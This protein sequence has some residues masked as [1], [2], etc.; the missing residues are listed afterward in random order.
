VATLVEALSGRKTRFIQISAAG[1]CETA[2]TEF[3]RS[4]MRGDRVLMDSALDWIILRPTLVL[5]PHAYG[6]TALLR[7]SA[8]FPVVGL[9]MLPDTVVQTVYVEDLVQAVVQ[10]A[11]GGIASGTIADVS[12]PQAHGFQDLVERVRRWQGFPAWNRF[13]RV[14]RPLMLLIARLADGL[15]WL[16][17]RS[18]LRTTAIL[19]LESGVTGNPDDGA[20]ANRVPCRSLDDTLTALPATVQERC[21]ARM[22]L[23]LPLAVAVLSLFWIVSGLIGFANQETAQ[24]V[25]TSRGFSPETAMSAVILGSVVDIVL[26]GGILVRGWARGAALGMIAVSFGYLAAAVIWTPDLWAHPLGPTVKVIPGMAL[27][28]VVAAILEPR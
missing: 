9:K 10:A 22:Y 24:A 17:W 27:A 3:M 26:G 19:A 15:G 5:S 18:P 12:E 7:A 13:M 28:A 11:V 6:G 25:L 16:G 23:M 2:S 20:A 14:P 4:K 1:V 8:A 21:F